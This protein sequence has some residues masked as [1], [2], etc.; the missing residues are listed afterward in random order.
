MPSNGGPPIQYHLV[1]LPSPPPVNTSNIPMYTKDVVDADKRIE[2]PDL[3]LALPDYNGASGAGGYIR[4]RCCALR[5]RGFT[6]RP[7]NTT[8]VSHGVLSLLRGDADD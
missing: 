8:S 1:A 3:N 2:E 6:H 5:E 7:L 4:H